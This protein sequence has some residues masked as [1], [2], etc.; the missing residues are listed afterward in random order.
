MKYNQTKM[1]FEVVTYGNLKNFIVSMYNNKISTG[2]IGED[3]QLG[4]AKD[5]IEHTIALVGKD[6]FES[7]RRNE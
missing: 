4:L 3:A 6:T 1:E 2:W 7:Y 5:L